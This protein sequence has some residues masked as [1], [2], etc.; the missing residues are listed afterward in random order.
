MTN[1]QL[2]AVLC[3]IA[4]VTVALVIIIILFSENRLFSKMER[5]LRDR[6]DNEDT[7]TFI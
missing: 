3:I 6:H 1:C 2:Y 5:E 7:Q 4:C